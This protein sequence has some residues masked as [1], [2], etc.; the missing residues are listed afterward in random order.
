[1]G[2][3]GGGGVLRVGG[4]QGRVRARDIA[5]GVASNSQ[6]V[7][8]TIP[9]SRKQVKPQ[10]FAAYGYDNAAGVIFVWG[11]FSGRE[12]HNVN[13]TKRAFHWEQYPS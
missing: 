3:W 8:D 6:C 1:M 5:R 12:I 13:P 7:T 11:Q 9:L 2:G 4:V 10:L